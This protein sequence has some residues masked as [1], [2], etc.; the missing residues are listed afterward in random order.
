MNIKEA[1]NK[2]RKN[3]DKL[4]EGML[5]EV[6]IKSTII[7]EGIDSQFWK[8]LSEALVKEIEA[9]R[10]ALESSTVLTPKTKQEVNNNDY[11][12]QYQRGCINALRILLGTPEAI[13][14]EGEYAKELLNKYKE[15]D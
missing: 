7:R 3:K 2:L 10:D 8:V 13:L 6:A 5:D 11:W 4:S 15:E 12:R 9:G 1:L 14:D